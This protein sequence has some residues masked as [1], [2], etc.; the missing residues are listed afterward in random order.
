MNTS[1]EN[2]DTIGT[3]SL[4]N[5]LFNSARQVRLKQAIK[6]GIAAAISLYVA[7]FFKLPEGY[8]AVI[9]T[10]IVMQSNVGATVNASSGRLAG[11]A[12]GAIMGGVFVAAIGSSSL[13]FILAVTVTVIVCASL[14]L[15]ESYRLAGVTVAIIM[16]V[17]HSG[18]G[19]IIAVHRFLEVSI[20]IVVALLVSVTVWPA[21]ARNRLRKEI[22][23]LFARCQ[24]LYITLIRRYQE[25]RGSNELAESISGLLAE[26][27]Q[28]ISANE[29][30]LKQALYEP[31][32]R[33]F[34]RP[35]LELLHGHTRRILNQVE[36]LELTTREG[37]GDSYFRLLNPELETGE[38]EISAS[39]LNLSQCVASGRFASGPVSLKPAMLAVDRKVSA[40]RASGVSVR[41]TA[42][43]ILRAYSFVLALKNLAAELDL[44]W[45]EAVAS[46]VAA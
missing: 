8:W 34:R 30:L 13:S 40:V 17:H 3:F 38:S 19:W 2:T 9:S 20:G 23:L 26:L 5:A 44:I 6:T 21:G 28:H 32:A 24:E 41:Y 22:S 27:D 7:R 37:D 29:E 33:S 39:L 46:S 1:N 43:E 36:T 15:F 16:L 4:Q 10:L 35:F 42:E 12:I 45:T 14:R 31:S 25:Q 11:T 18:P